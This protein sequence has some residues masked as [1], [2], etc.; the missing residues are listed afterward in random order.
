MNAIADGCIVFIFFHYILLELTDEERKAIVQS[1]EFVDFMDHSSKILERA[2]TEKYDFM[3][4]Y[5]LGLD[6]DT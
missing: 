1:A 6:N 2:M 4:D 5:T 3:K